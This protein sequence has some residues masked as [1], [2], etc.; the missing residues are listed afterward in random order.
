VFVNLFLN[1]SELSFLLVNLSNPSTDKNPLILAL[2]SLIFK[3]CLKPL[4]CGRL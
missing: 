3:N 2:L 1:T 4:I